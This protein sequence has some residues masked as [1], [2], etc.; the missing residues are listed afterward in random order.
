MLLHEEIGVD[1]LVADEAVE[2]VIER[3][4]DG[5]V[6]GHARP[7]GSDLTPEKPDL[8][9]EKHET[10]AR[11]RR[12]FFLLLL[13]QGSLSCLGSH[14]GASFPTPMVVAGRIQER[15]AF[16]ELHPLSSAA[17]RAASTLGGAPTAWTG[18]VSSDWSNPA[19]W[20]QG[21]PN[22]YSSVT[23]LGYT[24]YTASTSGVSN[25]AC[26]DLLVAGGAVLNL[27]G[28]FDV[29]QNVV[30]D[31]VVTGGGRIRLVDQSFGTLTGHVS[32][33]GTI[34]EL[35]VAKSSNG[36]AQITTT[37]NLGN[38]IVSSGNLQTTVSGLI[39]VSGFAHFQGGMLST[40][41]FSIIDVAGDVTF[42]GTSATGVLPVI[43]C[44]GNWTS[45][46]SFAP[47]GSQVFLHG[48]S[49][50]TLS[51]ATPFDQLGILASASV[52]AVAPLTVNWILTIDGSLNVASQTLHA[53][54]P[55]SVTPPATLNLGAGTH[56]FGDNFTMTGSLVATGTMVFDGSSTPA[57]ISST[58]ALPSIQ[59]AK[60]SGASAQVNSNL[61]INGNCVLTSGTLTAVQ[62][63]TVAVSGNAQFVGGNLASGGM[64]GVI[65]V[66]GNVTFSGT[67]AVGPTPTIRCGGNWTSN[68]AFAPTSCTVELDGAGP[69][70]FAHS[71]GPMTLNAL[72]IKNGPRTISGDFLIAASAITIDANASLS[73]AAHHLSVN[74]AGATSFSVN[75][76]LSVGAGGNLALG[77]NTSVTVAPS[78]SLS[79][80]GTPAQ[81]ARIT[82]Q[83]G[84]GYALI[85][86]GALSAKNFVVKEMNNAG[87]VVNPSAVI[88][89]APNDFRAGSFDFRGGAAPGAVL[90]DMR[91]PAAAT[92]RYSVFLNSPN[93]TGVFNVKTQSGGAPIGFTNWTG[94]FSGPSFENDPGNHISWNPPEASMLAQ[95]A[96]APGAS[97]AEVSWRTSSEVDLAGFELQRATSQAG[98]WTTVFSTPLLGP[99]GWQ[100]GI[101]D[102]PLTAGQTYLYT[103]YAKLTH[104]ALV[105]L[106]SGSTVPYSSATPAN[107]KTVGANGPF[108]TIQAAINAS[109]DPNSVVRVM[110]G[111]YAAFTIG[112]NSVPSNLRILGDD[113]GPV[114]IDTAT[115]PIQI[116]NVPAGSGIELS[117]LDVGSPA[118]AQPGI[119][120][121]N[122]ASPIVLDEVDVACDGAH[123]A[124]SVS[125]APKT[126]I[127]R[128]E[129]QGGTGLHVSNGSYVAISYGSL[130][131]LVSTGSTIEMASLTPGSVSVT[132]AG[133]LLA[134]AGVM[135]NIELPEVV[136]ISVPSVMWV[137]AA[138]NAPFTILA[139]PRLGFQT[140][141]SFAMPFLLDPVAMVQ[142][143]VDTTDALGLAAK[144]FEV[145][146]VPAVFGF[147]FTVQIA[148]L[149][150]GTGTLQLSNVESM[151]CVP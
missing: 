18:A 94:A 7:V 37:L 40:V 72:A 32:G 151:V 69:T 143:P 41:A 85:V 57:A 88:A 150:P 98:P 101:A 17:D 116:T 22:M 115:G 148:V 102:A 78:G 120:I 100:Y 77:P 126:A 109:S 6:L 86:N 13:S 95:F 36:I 62:A 15:T 137:T 51:A 114:F 110:P 39:T 104:D 27:G 52:T 105:A 97:L 139:S 5:V 33:S 118:T 45:D 142:L 87:M 108:T 16:H 121:A 46:A 132:P 58:A 29:L 133:S 73:V 135:P 9:R 54:G 2:D 144:G 53:N 119:A 113:S 75:G 10:A 20:T 96:A 71:G 24:P 38:L 147:A 26:A 125:N 3:R 122:C 28:T 76:G 1:E 31:G 90:L 30:V 35:E 92:F 8:G 68:G 64:S 117:N 56:T 111:T 55:V 65:D 89:S 106:A 99:V 12:P 130:S 59:I 128:S 11:K 74:Q 19:N 124:I 49:P 140:G 63:Y 79:L 136:H 149:D 131:S 134:R 80:V 47:S 25:A 14:D 145:A 129:L 23:I 66:A 48:T 60:T 112:G 34:G 4:R 93:I 146:P 44:G 61:T 141:P 50:Q 83:T 70:T 103:L 123:T 82:G 107:V 81:P 138:P 127:Q 43:R 91:R 67:S 84:G 42:S 21:V